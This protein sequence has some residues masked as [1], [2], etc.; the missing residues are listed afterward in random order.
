MKNFQVKQLTAQELAKDV[1][2]EWI[3]DKDGDVCLRPMHFDDG[4]RV[5]REQPDPVEFRPFVEAHERLDK[6]RHAALVNKLAEG[7][8]LQRLILQD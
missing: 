2:H 1:N 7:D 5:I 6:L 8:N 3:V 4:I